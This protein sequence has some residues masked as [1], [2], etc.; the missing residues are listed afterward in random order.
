MA[1]FYRNNPFIYLCENLLS[2]Q[3]ILTACACLV[4]G[5][6]H[7]WMLNQFEVQNRC[8]GI[9]ISSAIA[10]SVFGEARSQ[11]A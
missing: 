1:I 3:M 11:F 2:L 7:S 6:I 5:P 10:T 8:R 9:F 4:I